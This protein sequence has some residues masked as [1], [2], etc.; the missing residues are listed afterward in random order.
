M[1]K[2][3]PTDY[4]KDFNIVIQSL[5]GYLEREILVEKHIRTY[6]AKRLLNKRDNH[7]NGR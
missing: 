5:K 1:I 2:E 3:Q 6:R 4:L 7:D